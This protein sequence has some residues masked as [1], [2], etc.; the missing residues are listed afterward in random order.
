MDKLTLNNLTKKYGDTVVVDHLNLSLR[1]GE[2]VSLLGPSGCG[3]TTTLRMIAGFVTPSAGSIDMDGKQMS[4][5]AASLP[6]ER[7]RMSM[8]FQSYALWPNMTV[9]QNVAFGLKMRKVPKDEIKRRVNQ[10]LDVVQLGHL[11]AR[12]PNE[13]SGGQQ[14]RVS[15]ARALVVKPEILLLD[16]PL[17]NL[18][19]NLREEMRSEIRRLHNEFGITSIYVTHDQAEA[20][21]TSDRIAVMNKGRIEQIDDPLTLYARPKTRYVAEFI[22]RSNILDGEANGANVT[23]KGFEIASARLDARGAIQTN[24]FSLRSQNI[25]L[26]ANCPQGDAIILPGNIVERAFLG[27]TWDYAFQSEASD[28]KL[29]IMSPP[30][31]VFNVGQKV[32]LE[33]NPSH[34][35]P[36][37][38]DQHA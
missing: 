4:S 12:Y 22:G 7:R 2:F 35:I 18:D 32:W 6:P 13:L 16:E 29:R 33:I 9:A 5:A 14:Q 38:D 26:H 11:A 36:I 15:L 27:E 24:E 19:A 3:K 23:F 34:I 37:Q 10:I 1:P 20:M 28:L 21:T 17:S 25:G 30:L 8:I 31:N